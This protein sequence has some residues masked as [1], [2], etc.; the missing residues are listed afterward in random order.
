MSWTGV[1]SWFYSDRSVSTLHPIDTSKLYMH[2]NADLLTMRMI[3]HTFC[4]ETCVQT[5]KDDISR[6]VWV[7]LLMKMRSKKLK[8]LTPNWLYSSYLPSVML[9]KQVAHES[10]QIK[11]MWLLLSCSRG[12]GMNISNKNSRHDPS[13]CILNN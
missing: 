13:L 3:K 2:I 11:G 1:F 12:H 6:Q 7:M 4:E 10:W 5:C 8:L 9:H